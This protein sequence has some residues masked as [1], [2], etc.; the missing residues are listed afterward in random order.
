M[1]ETLS[2]R[3]IAQYMVTGCIA[4]APSI[5]STN[6][7]VHG[8]LLTYN[9]ENQEQFYMNWIA[10]LGTIIIIYTVNSESDIQ[11]IIIHKNCVTN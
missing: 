7:C 5:Q 4:C 10:C 11:N 2:G 9:I 3:Y 6:N 8:Q 1:L